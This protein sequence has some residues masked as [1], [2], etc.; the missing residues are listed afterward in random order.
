MRVFGLRLEGAV[1]LQS[2]YDE[3]VK[4][5]QALEAEAAFLRQDHT[6]AT[7][8]ATSTGEHNQ[9]IMSCPDATAARRDGLLQQA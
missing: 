6:R 2:K 3:A 4:K 8:V 1:E 5:L 9:K 7:A